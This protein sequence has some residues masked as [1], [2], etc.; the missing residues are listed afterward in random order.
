MSD[1]DC[2]MSDDLMLGGTEHTIAWCIAHNSTNFYRVKHF[3][4]SHNVYQL[5]HP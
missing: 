3:R 5:F 2:C 1:F 4:K